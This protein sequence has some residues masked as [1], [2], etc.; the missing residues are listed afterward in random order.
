MFEL[1][2]F[3]QLNCRHQCVLPSEVQNEHA[4]LSAMALNPALRAHPVMALAISAG[5]L[6]RNGFE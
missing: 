4:G 5:Q 1:D 6:A 3:G 2:S